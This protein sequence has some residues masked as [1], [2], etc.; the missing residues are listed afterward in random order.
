LTS[1]GTSPGANNNSAGPKGEKKGID[2]A[3]LLDDIFAEE[4]VEG[5]SLKAFADLEQLSA[6]EIAAETESVLQELRIRQGD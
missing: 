2:T 1:A 3:S 5:N 4:Q 6:V